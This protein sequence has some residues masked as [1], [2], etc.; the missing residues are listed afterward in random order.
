M[1]GLSTK[2]PLMETKIAMDLKS[3]KPYVDSNGQKEHAVFV[4]GGASSPHAVTP[5]SRGGN[6]KL[7]Q[8]KALEASTHRIK[9]VIVIKQLQNNM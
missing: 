2:P 8:E 7:A 1:A 3:V 6:N 4:N 5:P 9:R